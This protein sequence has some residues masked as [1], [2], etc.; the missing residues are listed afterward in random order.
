LLGFENHIQ[1]QVKY[2]LSVF[3]IVPI[4]PYEFQM[5]TQNPAVSPG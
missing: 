2:P 5:S 4:S 3:P 1:T